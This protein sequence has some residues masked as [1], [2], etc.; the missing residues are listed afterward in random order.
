ME[1]QLAYGAGRLYTS[2]D[3]REHGL[4]WMVRERWDLAHRI[5]VDQKVAERP[6]DVPKFFTTQFLK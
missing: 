4:L 5:M 6:I 3:T 1:R 2:P